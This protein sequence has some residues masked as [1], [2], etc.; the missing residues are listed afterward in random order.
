EAGA[1]RLDRRPG[2]TA[3]ADRYRRIV[4]RRGPK[5]AAVAVGHAILVMAYFLLTRGTTYRELDRDAVDD[6][7]RAR[8]RRRALDQL[9]ALGYEVVLTPRSTLVPS[10]TSCHPT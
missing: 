7:R 8:V 3:F 6:R 2:Q 5:R 1:P 4:V 9:G 10:P